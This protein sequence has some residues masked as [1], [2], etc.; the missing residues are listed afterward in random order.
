[1]LEPSV[2]H[3]L[4]ARLNDTGYSYDAVADRL[5]PSGLDG[6]ARNATIPADRALRGAHD[7]QATLIRAFALQQDVAAADLAAALG[8]LDRLAPILAPAAAGD[9][10]AAVRAAFEIRPYAFT[11]HSGDHSGWLASDLTPTLDGRLSVPSD[12]FVLG[13]SPASVTLAQLTMRNPR[14]R[15]LDLGAGCGIQS[16]HL[17]SHS[18]QVVATDLNP[19]ACAMTALTAALNGITV[20][21]RTGSLYEPVA[22]EAFDLIVTN[23]PYVMAPPGASRLVYR[24]GFFTADGLVRAVV[25][26]AAAYLNPGGAL[27][28]L[29][30]WAITAD[31]AWQE[32]LAS[33]IAPTGCDALVLQR[34][35]LDPFEYIEIW[36]ADAGLVG[37]PDYAQRY[38]EWVD[39]FEQLGIVGVGLGW[40][41][42]YNNGN[43]DPHLRFDDWPHQ[44]YGGVGDAFAEFPDAARAAELPDDQ[45]LAST[46]SLDPA[47]TS[48][49]LGRPGA[50]DPEHLVFRR[51]TGFGRAVEVDTAQGGVV[52]ACDG[53]LPL[54]V[55]I[56]AVA[57]L[58]D[59]NATALRADLLPRLRPLIADGFLRP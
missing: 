20:D 39:Y 3:D 17:A 26:G 2:A 37:T 32:R 4:A 21:V 45:L 38:A 31:E 13:L 49:A 19:R 10:A 44:V 55:L 34:E 35:R 50:P 41:T 23:P 1:M 47:V 16:L 7:P 56:D 52:G 40:L 25:T 5:G 57:D 8:D 59:V 36:L 28:V 48:E 11:D 14:G 54:G 18:E 22:G 58:L 12:D 46:L 6:L 29:G 51:Q 9:S 33:W 24:E 53:D 30:N 15:A 43:T 42:L 27:Q